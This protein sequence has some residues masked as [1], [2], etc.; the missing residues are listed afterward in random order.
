MDAPPGPVFEYNKNVYAGIYA[1]RSINIETGEGE[2]VIS[3]S[4]GAVR[5]V[6]SHDG[7]T[8]AYA[9]RNR[10]K[11]VLM[12]RDLASGREWQVFEGLERDMQEGW[13]IHGL[14]PGFAWTPDDSAIVIWVNG[15]LRKVD[16]KTKTATDIPFHVKDSRAITE[17]V[18]F[19]IEV[20][21]D[22]IEVKDLRFV[23]VSPMG[24]KVVF[25]ALGR[26]WIRDLPDG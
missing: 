9:H 21:P 24:D 2:N 17:A 1:I 7:K 5:P 8:L 26:L 20:A 18:R 4:G 22:K 19:P 12:L 16:V 11:E 6:V 14:Y 25:Q 15:K 23:E 10:L 13:A 3:G